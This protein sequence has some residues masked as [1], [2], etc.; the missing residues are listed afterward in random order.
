MPGQGSK[1]ARRQTAL[2]IKQILD[3]YTE[4]EI[5]EV[6]ISTKGDKD[7]RSFKDLVTGEKQAYLQKNWK[8]HC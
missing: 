5:E 7:R 8:R 6:V 2:I 3:K 4:L 1:L